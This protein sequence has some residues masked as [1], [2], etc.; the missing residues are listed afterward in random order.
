MAPTK[1]SQSDVSLSAKRSKSEPMLEGVNSAI[2]MSKSLPA[3]AKT[4]L[5]KLSPASFTTPVDQRHELQT[6]VV[7]MV[8][9]VVDEVK[10]Y[11][12]DELT[13]K[14]AAIADVE[15]DRAVLFSAVADAEVR[16][17]EIEST[18]ETCKVTL[19]DITKTFCSKRAECE[20]SKK[21]QQLDDERHASSVMCA[22]FFAALMES[23]L[24]P[25]VEGEL[26]QSDAEGHFKMLLP[27]TE[28]LNLDS[29]LASALS[30]S[31]LKKLCDRSSFDSIVVQE[32]A[33]SFQAKLLTLQSVVAEGVPGVQARSS[34]VQ[35]KERDSD[36]WREKQTLAAA[37]FLA[38]QKVLQDAC[39]QL[40]T[41]QSNL[42]TFDATHAAAK[43]AISRN[44]CELESFLAWNVECYNMLKDRAPTPDVAAQLCEAE[45][46]LVK[47]HANDEIQE[48]TCESAVQPESGAQVLGVEGGL[49]TVLT[50]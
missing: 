33:R 25:I 10:K 17:T 24:K 48:P 28:S 21:Q 5:V 42:A 22:D 27:S 45:E 3:E 16:K 29:S 44:Q 9:D 50:T 49:A 31:C 15:R 46:P 47:S 40:C 30:L 1:R 37:D 38:A 34:A 23:S 19:A 8:G 20:S 11:L 14:T 7:G 4:M 13:L 32:L 36:E 6:A 18:Q 39:A 12:S 2:E 43:D 41:A 26:E 35:A